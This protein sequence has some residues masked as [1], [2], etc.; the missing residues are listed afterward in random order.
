MASPR[1]RGRA[2]E[3]PAQQLPVPAYP[4]MPAADVGGVARG[5]PFEQLDIAQQARAGIA[6]LQ[7]VMAQ[8][9]V[10]REAVLQCRFECVHVVDALADEGAF[11]EDVLINVGHSVGIGI[12]AW[13][14]SVQASVRRRGQVGQADSHPRLQDAV[15]ACH[16][17]RDRVELGL[18]ERMRHGADK[19]PGGFPGQL[20]IGVQRDDVP[21][22]GKRGHVPDHARECARALAAEHAIQ[23]GK[24]SS[25]SL[26][27]HPDPLLLVPAARPVKEKERT[28]SQAPVFL[29]QGLH[30]CFG[31]RQQ[32]GVRRQVF[33]R[34]VREIRQQAEA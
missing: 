24:L 15:A 30:L 5:L 28:A 27:G 19:F 13:I 16:S 29:V 14:A 20:G 11:L 8:H 21:D 9:P 32:Q 12:D 34:G 31:A 1:L 22:P 4:A 26:I 17:A 25:F 18:I 33:R 7:Q 23:I 6:T 10:V 3:Q 2:A